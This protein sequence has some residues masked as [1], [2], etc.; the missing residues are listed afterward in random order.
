MLKML[1]Q[2]EILNN[3]LNLRFTLA[4]FLCTFLLVGSAA[5][6]LTDYLQE[7]KTYDVNRNVYTERLRRAT[8]KWHYLWSGKTIARE[9]VFT[10]VFAI[11]GEKDPDPRASVA[12][13]FSPYFAGD[14]KR[15]PLINLFP[16][17]DMVF[18][19]GVIVSLLIFVLTYDAIS[20]EREEGTLKVLL[21]CPVPRDQVI[22]AKWLGGFISLAI[23]FVTSWLVIGLMLFFSRDVTL[24]GA[25]WARMAGLF[26]VTILYIAAVFSMSMMVSA[27]AKNSTTAVLTLLLIWVVAIVLIPSAS[28]PLAYL[29]VNP[30]GVQQYQTESRRIGVVEYINFEQNKDAYLK[31]RFGGRKVEDLTAQERKEWDDIQRRWWWID[32]ESKVEGIIG[33]GQARLREEKQVELLA[34][35][36]G[37]LSPF[38]CLRNASVALA[39][40]GV[41]RRAA[42]D[43]SVEQ[44]SRETFYFVQ[45]VHE[46]G[47]K[48][49]DHDAA[50]NYR[51]QMSDVSAAYQRSLMDMALLAV[52]TV[53]FFLIGYIGF[54]RMEII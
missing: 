25:D 8:N 11:G 12:P 6:M 47:K 18:I 50:P 51:L 14:F 43:E 23:P 31:K 36:F 28:A 4:Y 37:R 46:Q 17:V 27:F 42:L 5:I 33:Q 41:N 1:I 20:G 54:I 32:L 48:E 16:T 21:S 52:M 40:T 10:R 19:V 7:K 15:N 2:K 26:L 13:E 9:P 45:R 24:T 35:W 30:A 3:L 34:R 53:L 39:G 49:I 38:G 22:L 44:Y 29:T